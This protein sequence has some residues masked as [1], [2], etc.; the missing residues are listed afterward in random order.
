MPIRLTPF[1]HIGIFPEQ[2]PNWNWLSKPTSTFA[3]SSPNAEQNQQPLP[4]ALNLFAYTGAS[5]MALATA[6]FAVA[7]VDAAKPSVAAAKSAAA[8]NRFSEHPIRYL[9]D[10][11]PK[12]VDRELRRR[13]QYSTIILDP[14]AYGHG[15]KGKAWRLERD[16]WPLLDACCEL[17]QNRSAVAAQDVTTQNVTTQNTDRPSL[18]A[19]LLVTG[20]SESVGQSE[21]ADFLYGKFKNGNRHLTV[22]TS[23]L[24][25]NDQ[26]DR[27]LDAG[28]QVRAELTEESSVTPA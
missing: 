16:L 24:G 28:F 12:F 26:N 27:T 9:V 10:D 21:I 15:P 14:P 23:R 22:N 20:H 18:K 2:Q 19:R 4:Q 3:S 17:M 11:V 5:T 6:G 13:K 1:G 8:L 25:I 7:H